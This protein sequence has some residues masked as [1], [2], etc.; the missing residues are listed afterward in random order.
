[1]GYF[2][3][4]DPKGLAELVQGDVDFKRDQFRTWRRF[5]DRMEKLVYREVGETAQ[6]RWN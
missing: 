2:D 3:G 4:L 1:M 6:Q 5:I